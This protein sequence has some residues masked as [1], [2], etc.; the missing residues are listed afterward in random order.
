MLHVHTM[1]DMGAIEYLPRMPAWQKDASF[2]HAA[3]VQNL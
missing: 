2:A 3:P 1:K